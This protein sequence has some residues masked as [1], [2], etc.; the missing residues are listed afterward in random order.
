MVI[1]RLWSW[2]TFSVISLSGKYSERLS[3]ESKDL[4]VVLQVSF[5]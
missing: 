3:V 1:L 4:L 5:S 2:I